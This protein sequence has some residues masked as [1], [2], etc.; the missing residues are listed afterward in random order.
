MQMPVQILKIWIDAG[1]GKFEIR[2]NPK[3]FPVFTTSP[4]PKG[5]LISFCNDPHVKLVRLGDL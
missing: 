4:W 1:R 2:K 3:I 5:E